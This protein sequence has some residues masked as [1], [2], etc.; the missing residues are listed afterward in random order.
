M[1]WDVKSE[2]LKM[3]TLPETISDRAE[4][5]EALQR[6]IEHALA[7]AMKGATVLDI[8][9]DHDEAGYGCIIFYT[10]PERPSRGIGFV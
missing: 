8:H 7:D 3:R 10:E 5:L 2:A 9:I 6:Q 4:T 1:S